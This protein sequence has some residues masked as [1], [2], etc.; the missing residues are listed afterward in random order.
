M[1]KHA[2]FI[3]I[4]ECSI[5]ESVISDFQGLELHGNTIPPEFNKLETMVIE[6][7]KGN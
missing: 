2:G 6:A 5:N 3:D 4:T 1:L 7:K